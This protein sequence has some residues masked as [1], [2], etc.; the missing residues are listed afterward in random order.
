MPN[1]S[2]S[3]INVING[4]ELGDTP[5]VSLQTS[6]KRSP[7][8][9]E[10]LLVF[11]D[12]PGVSPSTCAD[13]A[14]TLN[15]GYA[16]A[17]GG[18]TSALRLAIKLANDRVIQLNKGA[19]ISQ[20]LEGSI[21]CALITAESVVV[22]QAGPAVAF[23]RSSQGAFEV[24]APYADGSPQIVGMNPA[25]D[26]HF[27][28]FAP[29]TGDVFVLSGAHSMTG[30][31]DQLVN[32]CMARG[33]ARMVAGYLNANVKR[34]RLVGVAISVDDGAAKPVAAEPATTTARSTT[35]PTM[36]AMAAA[37]DAIV[38]SRASA[39]RG[40][41]AT[42]ATQVGASVA[43]GVGQAA[44]S[45]QRSMGVF[46]ARL[47]PQ[48][49]VSEIQERSRIT[50]FLLAATAVLL[51]IAI[52]VAVGVGYFQLSGE[53]ERLQARSNAQAQ[54]DLAA[55]AVA[56]AQAR[57]EWAKAIQLI[58][59]YERRSP[60]DKMTFAEARM[61]ARQ[62]L[63]SISNV[64]RVQPLALTQFGTS[65]PRRIAA[66]A[67]GVYA[68]DPVAR[69]G[70]YYVLNA[71][72]TGTTGKKVDITFTD[73]AT[74][75]NAA[76]TDVS[77]ATTT[78]ER[79]RTEG[80]IFFT[81]NAA[82]EYASATGKAAP[83]Q[84]VANADA[85]PQS[86]QA[87]ELYNNSA[88]LLDTSVGQIWKYSLVGGDLGAGTSYFRS[89]YNPLKESVDFAIDGAIYVLQKNGTILKYYG[90]QPVQFAITGLPE[91]FLQVNAIAVNGPDQFRGSVFVLDSGAGSVVELDKTGKF[92][93]QYRGANDEFAGARDISMDPTSNTLYVATPER[94]FSFAVPAPTIAP[95]ATPVGAEQAP[96][97]QPLPDAPQP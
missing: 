22:A 35:P 74:T 64:T 20:R 34:G 63:D 97:L 56:P 25:I 79:W 50:T 46:G 67:L 3:S 24:I 42:A 14:R 19:P 68:L 32:N 87:G 49:S 91:A 13:I 66:S 15:D 72:R 5:Q 85:S 90:R 39:V 53:A 96:D 4:E 84:F 11:I 70:E 83:M 21:S 65:A 88:Y 37:G 58:D 1:V 71:E 41:V 52:A 44:K 80:A 86:V 95:A 7:R 82:Y 60:E 54:I 57:A 94:L 81:P 30:V 45:I 43:A 78:N 76:L 40:D 61:R 29:Q 47:L 9:G 28:N 92:L 38:A 69:M 59:D 18:M 23:A 17:P 2:F 51:P 62:Q 33:D 8:A 75:T 27:N 36:P 26:V 12:L 73:G 89:A 16:R 77:W 10:T 48:E 6:G 31:T 93:R 55:Q